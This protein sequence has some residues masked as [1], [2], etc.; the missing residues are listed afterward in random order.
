MNSPCDKTDFIQLPFTQ[1]K[2]AIKKT[3]HAPRLGCR[4]RLISNCIKVR[5]KL[6]SSA[7]NK[8]K[9]IGCMLRN[10]M[11][12]NEQYRIEI[13]VMNLNMMFSKNRRG[14]RR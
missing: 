14:T 10:E 11:F 9:D 6:G 7:K 2:C 8:L 3:Y 5:Q 12:R 1:S 4:S 13:T